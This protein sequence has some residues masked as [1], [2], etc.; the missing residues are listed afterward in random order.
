MGETLTS[1]QSGEIFPDVYKG[2][3]VGM[4]LVGVK[5]PTEGYHDWS[6][7]RKE[8]GGNDNMGEASG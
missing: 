3:E 6:V 8:P 1:Q 5:E 7:V 2:L 4:S